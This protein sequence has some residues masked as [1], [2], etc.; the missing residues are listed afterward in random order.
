M[1]LPLIWKIIILCNIIVLF[2]IWGIDVIYPYRWHLFLYW[3]CCILF[4]TFNSYFMTSWDMFQCRGQLLLLKLMMHRSC[5]AEVIYFV[6]SSD[7]ENRTLSQMCGK[8]YLP[9]YL[10]RVGLVTLMY[11]ASFMALATF[12]PS[13]L[14]IMKFFTVVVWPVILWCSNIGDDAFRCCLYNNVFNTKC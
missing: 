3:S 6:F 13:L 9:I 8:L 11:I 1:F 7:M 10:L 14:I 12:C 4:V 2:R 5:G